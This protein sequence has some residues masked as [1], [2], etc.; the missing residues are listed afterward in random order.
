MENGGRVFK[1]QRKRRIIYNDDGDQMYG[2][3]KGKGYDYGVVDEQSFLDARTTPVFDTHV[4]TY[5]WCVGNGAN[6]PWGHLNQG[7]RAILP[8]LES[9]WRAADVLIKA[10]HSK[11][12]EVWASLRM[13][14]I[15]DSFMARTLEETHDPMKAKHP[16]W[17]I[18]K[19]EDK[20][21][22]RELT[23]RF[24]W[25]A[26]NFECEEVRNY[27]LDFIEK[28]AAAHDF[29][30]YDLDFTRFVWN[31]PLGRGI[32]LASL[33]TDFV[34]QVRA[35]LDAIGKKRGRPYTLIAHV[36]DSPE[37]SL[38]LGQDVEA[39]LKEG[40]VDILTVGMG[41]LPYALRLDEWK[42]LGAKYDVPIYPSLN[43][44]SFVDW[45][46]Q[47]NNSPKRFKRVSAWHEAIRAAAAWWW[48]CGA[49][50]IN[51]FNLYC[52]ED[53]RVGPMAKDLVYQPL[54]EVGDPATL[55]GKDKLY[56]IGS[57]NRGGFCHHGSEATSL[58][59]PLEKMERKLPLAIGPDADNPNTRFIIHFWITG[60]GDDIKIYMRLNHKLFKPPVQDDAS[61]GQHHYFIDVNSGVMR[62]GFNELSLWCSADMTEISSPVIVHEVLV[63]AK[64]SLKAKGGG[65]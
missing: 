36:M 27:R 30:G 29:D 58:P 3:E 1:T 52:Q 45:Y 65:V 17:L 60:G 56:G 16:E 14:D 15:H 19:V 64:Q 41:Y 23:E 2:Y 21:L 63:E 8:C 44:N 7:H 43:T 10:C 50:G 53:P 31:F 12:M 38:L 9:E 32:E 48:H 18:G 55:V 34:R 59:V 33:M 51:I 35:R 4:D 11:D 5:V 13:N 40:L 61:H 26:F 46:K 22:P 49:D 54:S 42:A 20:E 28:T 25:T 37:K 57:S 24:L 47:R 62:V 6:P 39:W